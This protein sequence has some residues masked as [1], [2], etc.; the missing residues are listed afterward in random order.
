MS[1][2]DNLRHC[3]KPRERQFVGNAA[4]VTEQTE[5]PNP[6][7]LLIEQIRTVV[8]EEIGAASSGRG[9]LLTAEELAD[10]LQV[11]KATVYEWVK[12]GTI[13]HYQAGRFVRFKLHE[14]LDSQ[15]KRNENPA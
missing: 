12:S 6:F 1:N 8:R 7:D 9:N 5:T 3:D 14:V 11:H 15:R 4:K 13:P 10:A 2:E